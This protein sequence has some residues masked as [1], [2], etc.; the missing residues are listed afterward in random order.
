MRQAIFENMLGD[1]ISMA[2]DQLPEDYK[3]IIVLS[4]LEDF[5]YEEIAQILEIPI[6]TVRSRLFRARNA[7]KKL[8]YD[9]AKQQG[10][11]DHRS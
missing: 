4:D 9:Y 6:G 3:T 8:L 10:Y 11:E 2:M 5:S 7:L 1:E